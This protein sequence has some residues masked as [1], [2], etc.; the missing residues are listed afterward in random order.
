MNK[1]DDINIVSEKIGKKSRTVLRYIKKYNLVIKEKQ[2]KY[3]YEV[4]TM[5]DLMK[6]H[7]NYSKVGEILGISDNAVKKRFIRL[8]Y[9]DNIKD[10]IKVLE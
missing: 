1:Y 7:H 8:G 10:L 9:P 3:S 2:P 6:M 4:N 5:V